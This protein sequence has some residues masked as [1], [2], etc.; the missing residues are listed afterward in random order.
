MIHR[1]FIALEYLGAVLTLTVWHVILV[2]TQI[3]PKDIPTMGALLQQWAYDVANTA[4]DDNWTKLKALEAAILWIDGLSQ[5]G[6][7]LCKWPQR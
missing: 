3:L 1:E 4:A 2:S 5:Y 6:M 7:R